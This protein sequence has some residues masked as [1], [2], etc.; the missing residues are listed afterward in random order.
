MKTHINTVKTASESL[1]ETRLALE[2][3][4]KLECELKAE[5]EKRQAQLATVPIEALAL[6]ASDD[7]LG[8]RTTARLVS[9]RDDI[10]TKLDLLPGIR[11]R[12]QAQADG[13]RHQVRAAVNAL[14]YH[15]RDLAVDQME[16]LQTK[17]AADLLATCGGS[18]DRAKAAAASVVEKSE[19]LEWRQTFACYTHASDSI[20]DAEAAIS[21]AEAF[22]RGEPSN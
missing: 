5:L 13:L 17:L 7:K 14:T 11:A 1:R 6:A 16:V 10:R 19:A 15:C 4:S 22:E 20:E 18:V 12:Y 3:L 8:N 2:N 9:F 21:L